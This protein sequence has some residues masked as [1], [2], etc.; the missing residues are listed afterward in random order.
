M[1]QSY[2]SETFDF[3]FCRCLPSSVLKMTHVCRVPVAMGPVIVPRTVPA[4]AGQPLD[5]AHRV[6]ESAACVS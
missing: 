3:Q 4:W 5:R 6:L 2:Y 1:F